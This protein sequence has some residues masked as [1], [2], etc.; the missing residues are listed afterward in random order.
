VF[1]N[2]LGQDEFVTTIKA[3]ILGDRLPPAV[4]FSG[5]PGSGKGTAALELAR[6]LSCAFG[7]DGALDGETRKAAGASW[8]SWNCPC[9]ACSRH[10]L[11]VH[12]DLL[13][14]GSRSFP[15]EITA[16][17]ELLERAPGPAS[18]YFFVRAARK[19][20]CR[21]DAA[22][23]AGEETRLAKAAPLLRE[24]EECLDAMA[25]QKAVAGSLAPGAP[26]AGVKAAAVAAKLEALVPDA[27]PVFMIRNL[28][29]WARLA[30]MGPRKTAIIENA[31]RMLESS[32][33]ALLKILEEP[34][35]SVR[36]VLASSRRS[37]IM[38][39]ILS[40]ARTYHFSPR[41]P[42]CTALVIERVFRSSESALSVEAF[43]AA[44]RPFPPARA[45]ELAESFL[46]AA[47]AARAGAQASRADALSA[48]LAALARASASEIGEH[49]SSVLADLLESTKDF[50]QK[51]DSLSSS[52]RAFLSALSSRLAALL[53]EEGMDAEGIRL[54][55]AIAA[56]VRSASNDYETLNR[57]PGLLAE[58]LMYAIGDTVFPTPAPAAATGRR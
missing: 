32:R 25:P 10:R 54:I 53:R 55:E 4:L 29:F 33:N 58:A 27:P 20:A 11:L 47:L 57:S 45:R 42:V 51:D 56:L 22:L 19:L 8:A 7:K 46:G 40:R 15:E 52:F 17:L 48:P 39:T 50:G 36:F 14:L 13:L 38:T 1:E 16:G 2:L 9:P 34:P 41:D 49:G 43:L 3:D 28:E 24:L 26:A 35:E 21:F 23:Y 12:P 5:P 18:A 44:R 30:P 37:A 6:A 31:D